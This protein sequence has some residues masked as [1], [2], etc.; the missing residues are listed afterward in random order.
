MAI[1]VAQ[2]AGDEDEGPGRQAEG[3]DVPTQ[4]AGVL[5]VEV[6]VYFAERGQS[7]TDTSLSEY[8]GGDDGDDEEDL[9]Q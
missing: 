3:D 6:V 7:L 1:H 9:A 8:L 4:L 5:D 2:T